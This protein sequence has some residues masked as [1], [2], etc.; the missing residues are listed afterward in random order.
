MKKILFI[1]LVGF[2]VMGQTIDTQETDIRVSE[3]D[4]LIEIFSEDI[5]VKL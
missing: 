4:D 1:C 5:E 3:K 2:C